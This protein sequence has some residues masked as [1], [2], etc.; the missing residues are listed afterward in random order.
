LTVSAV[1]GTHSGCAGEGSTWSKNG[2]KLA[3]ATL[4]ELFMPLQLTDNNDNAEYIANRSNLP[5]D[6]TC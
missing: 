1:G 2:S 6:I 3:G 5:L 4:L